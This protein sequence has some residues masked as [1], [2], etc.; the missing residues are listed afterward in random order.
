MIG[1]GPVNLQ[2]K[3]Q[4]YILAGGTHPVALRSQKLG[5]TLLVPILTFVGEVFVMTNASTIADKS[6]G[7]ITS[8]AM[9]GLVAESAGNT[10]P[11]PGYDPCFTHGRKS[12]QW[13]WI[14][15]R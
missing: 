13:P 6:Y 2:P 14:D 4:V 12:E 7:D 1:I 5:D 15:I 10:A 3:D 11:T 9:G 8:K